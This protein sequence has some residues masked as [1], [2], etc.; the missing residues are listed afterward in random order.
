MTSSKQ[1]IHIGTFRT[2]TDIDQWLSGPVVCS[3]CWL[4]NTEPFLSAAAAAACG[5]QWIAVVAS[6]LGAAPVAVSDRTDD[7]APDSTLHPL[8]PLDPP[9]LCVA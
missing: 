5:P 4:G 1:I 2:T 3:G 9:T 7:A 6:L 8:V